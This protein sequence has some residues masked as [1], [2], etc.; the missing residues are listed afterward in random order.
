MHDSPLLYEL[1]VSLQLPG[2][3]PLIAV[4]SVD[5]QLAEVGPGGFNR[6]CRAEA[7][8]AFERFLD[9]VFPRQGKP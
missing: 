8:V 4:L 3:P 7:R 2:K 9:L 5:R 1:A 6:Y